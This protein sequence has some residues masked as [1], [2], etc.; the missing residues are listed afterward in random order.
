MKRLLLYP[1]VMVPVVTIYGASNQYFVSKA[2]RSN[3]L[4]SE[5]VFIPREDEEFIFTSGE[6]EH[7]APVIID[8]EL[9]IDELDE[10]EKELDE[11][12]IEDQEVNQ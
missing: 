9:I 4:R 2:Q 6:N 3:Y 1:M 11:I 8:E 10:F 12:E 5:A 7:A